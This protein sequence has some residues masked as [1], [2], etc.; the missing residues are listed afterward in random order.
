MSEKYRKE[1]DKEREKKIALLLEG[2]EMKELTQG[3]RVYSPLPFYV[4]DFDVAQKN[5]NLK[6]VSR[7]SYLMTINLFLEY[8]EKKYQIEKESITL[9][10]LENLH[11]TEIDTFFASLDISPT[12]YNKYHS[13]L[14][15]FFGFLIKKDYIKYNVMIKVDRARVKSYEKKVKRLTDAQSVSFIDSIS[16]GEGLTKKQKIHQTKNEL[17]DRAICLTLIRTGLRVS[18]LVGLDINDINFDENYLSVIRKGNKPDEVYFDNEVK[19]ALKE[20][21]DSLPLPHSPDSPVFISNWGK[22]KGKRI[23]VRQVEYQV[24]KYT[25]LAPGA[26]TGVSPHKLRA[27]FAT[28]MLNETGN[29]RLVQTQLAHENIQTTSIYIDENE[30]IKKDARNILMER[31]ERIRSKGLNKDLEATIKKKE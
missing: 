8:L 29:I 24:K 10:M 9:E 16:T 30:Q 3:E 1:Q 14:S 7:L 12:S 18:E 17:R 19:E 21:I 6:P 25:S 15:S 5:R 26:G 27:T 13:A 4:K 31:D 28:Q 22:N 23:T 2:N 11:P 20:Y